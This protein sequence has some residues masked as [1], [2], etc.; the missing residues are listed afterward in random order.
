MVPAEPAEEFCLYFGCFRGSSSLDALN[1]EM[2]FVSF[3]IS[4]ICLG[5]SQVHSD[6]LG[7]ILDPII[8]FVTY[9]CICFRNLGVITFSP[10]YF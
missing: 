9:Q 5:I 1:R 4:Y 2:F 7:E 6:N 8:A 3:W 10:S